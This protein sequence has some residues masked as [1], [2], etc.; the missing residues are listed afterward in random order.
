MINTLK[1]YNNF[2]SN[3]LELQMH[4]NFSFLVRSKQNYTDNVLNDYFFAD[5]DGEYFKIPRKS[6]KKVYVYHSFESYK[7]IPRSSPTM[8]FSHKA[9]GVR[10]GDNFWMIGGNVNCLSY[11]LGNELGC[12]E[13]NF[14]YTE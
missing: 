10:V 3:A 4:K 13:Q 14:Q 1:I 7:P 2:Q 5:I 12:I 11:N 6:D 9:V 8:D